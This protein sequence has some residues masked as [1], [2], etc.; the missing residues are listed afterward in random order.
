MN[1]LVQEE[2]CQ[3]SQYGNNL[4]NMQG[5]QDQSWG[6]GMPASTSAFPSWTLILDYF[7][8]KIYVSFKTYLKNASISMRY[9]VRMTVEGS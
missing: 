4:G 1:K 9:I 3:W 8:M 6:S 2:N 7:Y 5:D